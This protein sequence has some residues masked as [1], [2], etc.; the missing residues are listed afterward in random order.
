M[1]A[2]AD[3]A[4]RTLNVEMLEMAPAV[5]STGHRWSYVVPRLVV[6]KSGS[7]EAWRGET[8]GEVQ[9]EQLRARIE[10]DLRK[11]VLTWLGQDDT[12]LDIRI[13][14]AGRPMPLKGAIS[15][16]RAVTV[17]A[18]LDVRFSSAKRLEGAF[19]TGHLTATGHGRVFR[20]GKHE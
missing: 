8:L 4:G 17:M 5:A 6:S 1:R 13:E 20:D 7:W 10:A 18:R 12:A 19:F 2:V 9:T 3:T 16:P 15:A 14:N 11:Q